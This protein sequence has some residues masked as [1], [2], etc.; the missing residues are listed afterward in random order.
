[1]K[2][3]ELK[4]DSDVAFFFAGRSYIIRSCHPEA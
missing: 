1:M 3:K 2:Q 4:S